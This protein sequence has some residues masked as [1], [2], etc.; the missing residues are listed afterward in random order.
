M[1]GEAPSEYS[2]EDPDKAVASPQYDDNR[3]SSAAKSRQ[4]SVT[5][6][7][8]ALWLGHKIKEGFPSSYLQ[9]RDTLANAAY[10]GDWHTVITTLEVCGPLFGESWSNAFRLSKRP[11]APPG[12]GIR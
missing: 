8:P 12:I 7:K 10:R 2:H 5:T 1:L 11:Y 9:L 3:P 6:R 4:T